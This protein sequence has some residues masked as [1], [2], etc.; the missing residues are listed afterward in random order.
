MA[1]RKA[2]ELTEFQFALLLSLPVLIFLVL[3]MI[4]PL[5]YAAWMSVHR[6]MF[7]GGYRA[8]FVGLE[9]FIEIIRSDDFWHAT[10]VSI[11]FTIESVVLT[12]LIGLGLALLLARPFPGRN[13]VRTLVILPWAL[14]VYGTGIMFNYLAR[15]Q[16]GLGTAIAAALGFE[17]S[18]GFLDRA[19]IIETLVIANAWNMA[20][21]VAFFLLANLTT[22]PRRLYDLADIDRMNRLEK[23]LH[24]SLPP[25][26]FTLFVF[27]CVT[28]VLSLKAFDLVFM[29]SGGGPGKTSTTI[30]YELYKVTFK[31]LDFGYGAA[32]SFYLLALI[33]GSTLVLYFAWG[34]REASR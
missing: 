30:T 6:I 12:M 1:K 20:P 13:L 27:T 32:M 14:S 10:W 16:T 4:Y 9:N 31:N 33:V 2:K 34:R 26:R 18:I 5:V 7:F 3:I 24:V 22:I 23:F 29:L 25:L 21:L 28:T 15:G 8:D 19:F 11:R 17:G